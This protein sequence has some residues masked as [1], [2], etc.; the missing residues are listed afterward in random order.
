MLRIPDVAQRWHILRDD[1]CTWRTA[2]ARNIDVYASVH[3]CTHT[4]THTHV[5]YIYVHIHV[6]STQLR[7][8]K[9]HTRIE[10]LEHVVSDWRNK[11]QQSHAE[12]I[13]LVTAM[14]AEEMCML[15]A[16]RKLDV[17]RKTAQQQLR[18]AHERVQE[19]EHQ[20]QWL[21]AANIEEQKK[22]DMSADGES[23]V[24]YIY[25]YIYI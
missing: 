21:A 7:A 6:Y 15:E 4:H 14:E 11:A 2:E 13:N 18:T 20:N 17:A 10:N 8:A 3:A 1:V 5:T 16:L 25:I 19:L 9:A 24:L 22:A 12:K 23:K